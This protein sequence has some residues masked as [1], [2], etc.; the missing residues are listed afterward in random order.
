MEVLPADSRG[1]APVEFGGPQKLK[2]HANNCNNVLIKSPEEFFT[3]GISVRAY[4]STLPP[5]LSYA[6]RIIVLAAL[7]V[8]SKT[9]P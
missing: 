7:W 8:D 3:L 2:T 4:M 6:R 9:A 5:P 1:R